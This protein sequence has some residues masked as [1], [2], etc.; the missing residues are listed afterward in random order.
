MPTRDV[1][2]ALE[3]AHRF[4]DEHGLGFRAYPM[5]EVAAHP[6]AAEILRLFADHVGAA[7]FEPLATTGVPLATRDDWREVLDAAAKLGTTTVWVAFHGIGTDHDRQVNRPGAYGETCRAIQRVHAAGLRAGCNVFVTK[8]NAPQ[9]E[10]LLGA[11]QRLE[12][13]EMAWEPATYYPRREGGATS[14][15][16]QSR[17][18]CARSLIG[19][20]R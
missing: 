18:T 14:T 17:R 2:M 8:A 13:D 10:R 11:L 3:Q 9:A 20:A 19:S 6:D 16:A 5:H 15:C 12:I 1:A 4:C 7:E